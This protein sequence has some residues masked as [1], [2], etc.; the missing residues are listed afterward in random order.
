MYLSLLLQ[1]QDR[2]SFILKSTRNSNEKQLILLYC[3][4]SSTKALREQKLWSKFVNVS[5][6]NFLLVIHES[7]CSRNIQL[8]V[9]CKITH[10]PIIEDLICRSETFS[11]LT[12]IFI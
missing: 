3:S 7:L 6:A 8:R 2:T 11:N 5:V 1:A 4:T 10:L 12:C 9:I